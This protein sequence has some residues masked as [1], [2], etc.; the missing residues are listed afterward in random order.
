MGSPDQSY[1]VR[2]SQDDN[3]TLSCDGLTQEPS[4][5]STGESRQALLERARHM[6]ERRSRC[7]QSWSLTD[8]VVSRPAG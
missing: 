1:I 3:A 6:P 4:A 7:E 5:W 8:K 2:P